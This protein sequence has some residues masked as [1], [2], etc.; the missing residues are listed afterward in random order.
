MKY[1][2]TLCWFSCFNDFYL[3]AALWSCP[4]HVGLWNECLDDDWNSFILIIG[5]EYKFMN[6]IMYKTLNS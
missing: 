6:N 3:F 5:I 4:L 1:I 2:S